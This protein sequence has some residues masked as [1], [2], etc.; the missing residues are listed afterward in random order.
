MNRF[1]FH[2]GFQRFRCKQCGRTFSDIPVRPLDDLRIAPEKAFQV[3]N[4][5]AEGFCF[6]VRACERLTQLNRRTILGVLETAGQKC[7]RL[8]DT[9]I[10]D[11][12]VESV[13]ADEIFAFVYCKQYNNLLK[14]PEKGEQYTFL[15]ID[16]GSK[17]ILSHY[18]GKRTR[19]EHLHFH[20]GPAQ[21]H[22]RPLPSNNGRPANVCRCDV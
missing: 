9:K 5:L 3:I 12:V 20:C 15:A 6:G 21:A 16:R 18:V 7:A 11:V 22:Q 10:R 17:L 2:K 19:P 8:L 14:D 13:Q 4:L 1:G